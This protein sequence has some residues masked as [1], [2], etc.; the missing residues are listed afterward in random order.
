MANSAFGGT[1]DSLPG[2]RLNRPH[3]NRLPSWRASDSPSTPREPRRPLGGFVCEDWRTTM[4][5]SFPRTPDGRYFIVHGRLL[6]LHE[7]YAR[8]RRKTAP[9]LDAHGR[10]A[11]RGLRPQARRPGRAEVRARRG[12][13]RQ[14]RLWGSADPSG[15]PTAPPISIGTCRAPRRTPTG[16][17]PSSRISYS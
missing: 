7:P 3:V 4:S 12:G 6:A 5:K 14:G 16:G 2:R 13:R 1:H 15:G 17:A 9:D 11:R 8:R 10:P